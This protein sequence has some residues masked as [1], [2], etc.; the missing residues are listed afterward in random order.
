MFTCICIVNMRD[1]TPIFTKLMLHRQ[2]YVHKCTEIIEYL[3]D[4]L[5]TA[6]K[7]I[8]MEE[9]ADGW[10]NGRGLH[11]RPPLLL[12]NNPTHPQSD[13]KQRKQYN[14]IQESDRSLGR[15]RLLG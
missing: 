5:I 6:A 11:I 13:T 3:T 1:T 12:Q 14:T 10:R 15:Y 7:S 9:R 2:H 4:D 8:Q